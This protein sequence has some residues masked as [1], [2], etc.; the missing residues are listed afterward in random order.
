MI[1]VVS[2][3]LGAADADR[4][5]RAQPALL[6]LLRGRRASSQAATRSC[7]STCA[8]PAGS[9]GCLD[10]LGPGEQTDI[11]TAVEYAAGAPWSTGRV[12]MYGK[13]YDANLGTAAAA[14][15]PEGLDAVVAQQAVPDRYRGSYNDGVRFLQ[16]LAY[17]AV[18]YG[19][20]AEQESRP[21]RA[22]ST[23]L[24]AAAHSAD[25]QAVPRR[26]LPRRPDLGLLDGRATSS[27]A[28]R[29]RRSRRS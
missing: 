16:S 21:A 29:A 22:R 23:S 18:S 13:S 12:G 3:Y 5:A 14:L 28:A 27:S 2:P 17:P 4:G 6:R 8:A 1:L 24:N 26:A 15:Q 20:L 7:R 19:S 11:Q 10:I 9:T 25:C